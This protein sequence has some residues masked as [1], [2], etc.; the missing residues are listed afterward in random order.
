MAQP[1]SALSC[2]LVEPSYAS[3]K[4]CTMTSFNQQLRHEK[5]VSQLVL[6]VVPYNLLEGYAINPSIKFR[7]MSCA[8]S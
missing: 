3:M 2:V 4:G 7:M 8:F 1:R 5:T 6:G